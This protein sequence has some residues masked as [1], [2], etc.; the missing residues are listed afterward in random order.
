MKA[1]YG[2]RYEDYIKV[3]YLLKRDK[4]VVYAKDVA[5]YLNV[6]LP[7]V[8]EYLNKLSREGLVKYE[9][10]IVDLTEEGIEVTK[11][12]EK[13]YSTIKRFLVEVLKVPED[14]ADM[15][16]CYMEHGLSE[17]TIA[18]MEELLTHL[19]QKENK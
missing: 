11:K 19:L 3:I 10:G 16:A 6:K 9:N 13:R 15:D 18:K 2:K 1:V 17:V 7:T 5:N 12:I 14:Y 4:G 8:I